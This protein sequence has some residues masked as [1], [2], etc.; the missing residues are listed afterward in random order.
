VRCEGYVAHARLEGGSCVFG[1]RI[2]E[3]YEDDRPYF[4]AYL[5][6]LE[7]GPPAGAPEP[8]SS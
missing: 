2:D 4:E 7:A 3:I 1:I 5:S 8:A 6:S